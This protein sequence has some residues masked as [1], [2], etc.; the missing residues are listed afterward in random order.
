MG[1]LSKNI[2]ILAKSSLNSYNILGELSRTVR[3]LLENSWTISQ[4][5]KRTIRN[6]GYLYKCS[7]TEF[8]E[9]KPLKYM[10]MLLQNVFDVWASIS[11]VKRWALYGG[12]FVGKLAKG[13]FEGGVYGLT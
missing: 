10:L 8:R 3:E 6:T 7:L 2:R 1:D 13:V 5:T 9:H 11:L 12:R 4:K